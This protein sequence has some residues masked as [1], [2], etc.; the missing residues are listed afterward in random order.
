MDPILNPIFEVYGSRNQNLP[1]PKWFLGPETPKT[2]RNTVVQVPKCPKYHTLNCF[3]DRK[4]EILCTWPGP[5][6]RV[7]KRRYVVKQILLRR[8]FAWTSKVPNKMATIP[9]IF[10]LKAICGYFGGPGNHDAEELRV[11][12]VLGRS[13]NNPTAKMQTIN[14]FTLL[15]C[16]PQESRGNLAS[17]TPGRIQKV[18]PSILDAADLLFGSTHGV[19]ELARSHISDLGT[20][21]RR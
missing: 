8:R 14:C 19:W 11:A 12:G 6:K 7:H 5:D 1:Y 10:G 15:A 16:L 9:S 18:E 4:P 13:A 17:Q 21:I 20:Y 2:L 3:W